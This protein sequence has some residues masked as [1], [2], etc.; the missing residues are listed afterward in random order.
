MYGTI[1]AVLL[2]VLG[3]VASAR[4]Q[5]GSEGTVED[6]R[7]FA[8]LYG[9]VR[10][11][12]PSDEVAALD[13]SRFAVHGVA[14]VREAAS[15]RELEAT[16][17]SLF[18]PVAPTIDVYRVGESSDRPPGGSADPSTAFAAWQHVGV[19]LGARGAP[20][21]S[22]RLNRGGHDVLRRSR[23]GISRTLDARPY[24]GLEIRLRGRTRAE[25]AGAWRNRGHLW[26]A[27]VGE[28]GAV[29]F[30]DRMRDR[31]ILSNEWRVRE[32]SGVVDEDGMEIGL[33][34]SLVGVGR[35]WVDDFELS[36]REPG[37]A[38]RSVPLDNAGFEDGS[39]TEP[40][41][42]WTVES[43]GASVALDRDGAGTGTAA[44][45]LSRTRDRLDA[46]L[47]EGG[48][49][50]G[51]VIDEPLGAGLRARVPLTLAVRG[52]RTHPPSG[53]RREDLRA[54]LARLDPESWSGDDPDVRLAA[55]VIA[56]NV[57]EHFYPYFEH[58][59]VDREASLTRSLAAALEDHDAREFHETLEEMIAGLGDGHAH[60]HWF[61]EPPSAYLPVP[62]DRVEGRIVVV[63][64]DRPEIR[65][66]DVVTSVDRV[67]AEVALREMERRVS[68]SPRWKQRWVLDYELGTGPIG[69][70]ATLE[71]ETPE[72]SRD[73]RV[74]RVPLEERAEPRRPR[75]FEEIEPGILYVDLT[76]APMSAIEERMDDLVAAEG[77]VFDVR[78]YPRG[79]HAVLRHLLS[80]PDT[81]DSWFR[82]PRRV[83]PDPEGLVGYELHG[84]ELEPAAPPIHA[85]VAFLVDDRAISYAEG[86]LSLAAHY[87]LGEIVG[88]PSAG[89]NGNVNTLH[90]PGLYQITFTGTVVTRP[91]GSRFHGVGVV[92]T[93]RVEPTIRGVRQGRDE[94]LEGAVAAIR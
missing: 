60:A 53:P 77:I 76:S 11:F 63:A 49:D 37:G 81:T 44:A 20:Y 21:W 17:E 50:P 85:E 56:W 66:G 38:W 62:L 4:G 82:L 90:L 48:P 15:R 67:P 46:P 34:A 19:D 84:W 31:P 39:R 42:G 41:P 52:D 55:V 3:S 33:G 69:S 65:P 86:I 5:G 94:V 24:R 26:L 61:A 59:D 58:A 75:G 87:D 71:L 25:V 47:F 23:T 1:A 9:Y 73:V 80:T 16:L 27:V 29:A 18:R 6:L 7:A 92:P 36:V 70:V 14:R 78:G 88:R 22:Y 64:S 2:L 28:D 35:L 8:K 68:G 32:I 91:D 43:E 57:L 51:E 83:S 10:F 93:V 54:A 40:L 12:H 72:G 13:W 89:A 74:A 79:N 45:R 30:E